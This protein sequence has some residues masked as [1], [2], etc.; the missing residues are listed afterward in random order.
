MAPPFSSSSD[1]RLT[2]T[3]KGSSVPLK[4]TTPAWGKAPAPEHGVAANPAA[5]DAM[6]VDERPPGGSKNPKNWP[7]L[8]KK[9]VN[10]GK[11]KRIEEPAEQAG[12]PTKTEKP[13]VMQAA[14]TNRWTVFI[15]EFNAHEGPIEPPQE[16]SRDKVTC[17][18]FTE[19]PQ[20]LRGLEAR[21]DI[22]YPPFLPSDQ[23]KIFPLDIIHAGEG[24][25]RQKDI[26]YF[27]VKTADAGDERKK[28][29]PG[30][31]SR[32]RQAVVTIRDENFKEV[33]SMGHIGKFD[34]E[35]T[36]NVDPRDVHFEIRPYSQRP[37]LMI[38]IITKRGTDGK[39]LESV[40]WIAYGHAFTADEAT[41]TVGI[42]MFSGADPDV[43][44]DLSTNATVQAHAATDELWVAHMELKPDDGE[45]ST[46]RKA[47][48][49]FQ[50]ISKSRVGELAM[51][52]CDNETKLTP[53]EQLIVRLSMANNISVYS[54]M[55]ADFQLAHW[56]KYIQTAVFAT[57]T[58]GTNWHYALG[59]PQ[60]GI[61]NQRFPFSEVPPPRWWVK[62]WRVWSTNGVVTETV[63]IEWE[64][65]R[66]WAFEEICDAETYDFELRCAVAREA[67]SSDQRLK[68]LTDFSATI[69]LGS[70]N[71]NEAGDNY[72]INVTVGGFGV[73]GTG[74]PQ[75]D[76]GRQCEV[77]LYHEGR[78]IKMYGTVI[79][80]V[81]SSGSFITISATPDKPL[82]QKLMPTDEHR[83]RLSWPAD[84]TATS[85]G[86]NAVCI[87]E[88]EQ[89]RRQGP[90][91]P[92][93]C[94]GR[95]L[96]NDM[97]PD[98]LMRQLQGGDQ[99]NAYLKELQKH[100]LNERQLKA[101]TDCFKPN[102]TGAYLIWG[103][104]G[105][106]KTLCLVVVLRAM[107]AAGLRVMVCASS[108]AAVNK[109]MDV[110]KSLGPVPGV[111]DFQWCR[112]SG[113]L[114]RV[115]TKTSPADA[116]DSLEP[117]PVQPLAKYRGAW[118]DDVDE[119][120]QQARL[121][122]TFERVTIEAGMNSKQPRAEDGFS[123]KNGDLQDHDSV[124]ADTE[125]DVRVK[126]SL[127][128]LHPTPWNGRRRFAMDT[129]DGHSDNY[130]GSPSL[131]NRLE[132]KFIVQLIVALMSGADDKKLSHNDIVVLTPYNGQKRYITGLLHGQTS[133][134]DARLVPILSIDN[135]QGQ[136]GKFVIVSL[137]TNQEGDAQAKLSFITQEER[138]C[139]AV[140]RAQRFLCIVGN[141]KG[142][143]AAR[144]SSAGYLRTR[145]AGRF[146]SLVTDLHQKR[147][148]I[149]FSAFG[150]AGIRLRG[151]GT[152]VARA[153]RGHLVETVRRQ[154]AGKGVAI[155]SFDFDQS[156]LQT[157]ASLLGAS[158]YMRCHLLILSDALAVRDQT[159]MTDA[160]DQLVVDLS[161]N[162]HE[163][164]KLIADAQ[165]SRHIVQ[166]AEGHVYWSHF[167][168][169]ERTA[170]PEE[171]GVA[172]DGTDRPMARLRNQA[173]AHLDAAKVICDA[174][175]NQT[176]AVSHEIAPI[177][178]MLRESVFYTPVSSD[179]MRAVVAAMSSEFS[180]SGTGQ[181]HAPPPKG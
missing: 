150:G 164:E 175:L 11:D 35:K 170:S 5:E 73:D 76:L 174:A 163:C 105:T 88:H 53:A 34:L 12:I 135:A 27:P 40:K 101:G 180:V 6:E 16:E 81:M 32:A 157:R 106:G 21:A 177:R 45:P 23:L 58:L 46:C 114:S 134:P 1:A 167:A 92:S 102:A 72:I 109:A 84:Q 22:L 155:A 75:P 43:K 51:Q 60:T 116:V 52:H 100:N 38:K 108:N 103:P 143:I 55:P 7:S 127:S 104:P 110:F 79:D 120:E 28:S 181:Y 29:Q 2:A 156:L 83:L 68:A 24:M 37:T 132:G 18:S 67:E 13:E 118:A 63:P 47:R 9:L 3:P 158:L 80:D 141:F 17:Q 168:A 179:E 61:T 26:P 145:A 128:A 165:K 176:R 107:L 74:F 30:Y 87:L 64:Q 97:V 70:F 10:K 147:D 89:T 137:T 153:P 39:Q 93:L 50:G 44:T 90:H 130:P 56:H 131:R 48:P 162:R 173:V 69:V 85:R 54:Q 172:L 121:A 123:A 112:F 144:K 115:A 98:W 152:I 160:G 91:F 33:F 96:P 78:R 94:L 41:S 166:E 117:A 169:L 49:V 154:K 113:A 62:K 19:L 159:P 20:E 59:A 15:E 86:L 129:S 31:A 125:F 14:S 82:V 139:V 36:G 4:G 148:I 71:A 65:F 111:A 171:E 140:S 138:V 119:S 133:H 151:F 95:P 122:A 136:E 77:N 142:W 124:K 57:A 146:M 66:V 42:N 8:P 99:L 126:E 178:K 149:A 161:M 25:Y